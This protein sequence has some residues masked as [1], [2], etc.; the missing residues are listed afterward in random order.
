MFYNVLIRANRPLDAGKGLGLA[1]S[2]SPT[3]PV[4]GS[5]KDLMLYT[6]DQRKH[7]A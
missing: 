5:Q 1:L 6:V 4:Q 3:A 7:P 2:C